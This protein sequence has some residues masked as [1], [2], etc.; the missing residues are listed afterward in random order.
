MQDKT[1]SDEIP[2]AFDDEVFAEPNSEVIAEPKK[3]VRKERL[4]TDRLQ[5][6]IRRSFAV[7]KPSQRSS[8]N[9]FTIWDEQPIEDSP[10]IQRRCGEIVKQENSEAQNRDPENDPELKSAMKA[11]LSEI[12]KIEDVEKLLEIWRN[13]LE[14]INER[15]KEV[16]NQMKVIK[17]IQDKFQTK[18]A[19][20][21]H[22]SKSKIES[23]KDK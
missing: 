1:A 10:E 14:K 13:Q 20:K 16:K 9:L 11:I 15:R 4:D 23:N 7:P 21:K 6:D 2:L 3:I 17:N 5:E 19:K 12:P 8:M 18:I 22:H